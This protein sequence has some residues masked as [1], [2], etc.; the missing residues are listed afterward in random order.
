[1]KSTPLLS[2]PSDT[3]NLGTGKSSKHGWLSFWK[4]L[5]ADKVLQDLLSPVFAFT[6]MI[7]FAVGFV[8]VVVAG[9]GCL[10][11]DF[12][13]LLSVVLFSEAM[14]TF[15]FA[16]F[17][18]Y[19]VCTDI[20]F[21]SAIF[22][23]Q[24]GKTLVTMVGEEDLL[25]YILISQA[26][27]SAV[28]GASLCLLAK[29][30][31][32]W[33]LRFLPYPVSSG[34]AAGIGI[35]IMDGGFELG[36]GIGLQQFAAGLFSG[37]PVWHYVQLALTC[38]SAAVFLALKLVINNALR[39][40]L[41]ILITTGAVH[42]T[43]YQ[44]KFTMHDLVSC[45]MMLEGLSPEPWS[46]AWSSLAADVSSVD[47]SIFVSK[48]WMGIFVPYIFLHIILWS[49]YVSGF[50]DTAD[51]GSDTRIDLNTEVHSTGWTNIMVGLFSGVP[52]CH[53]YKMFLVMKTNGGQSR[54]WVLL[55]GTTF[56]FLFF[57]PAARQPLAV[58]PKLTFGG[59]VLSMGIGFIR[60]AFAQAQKRIAEAER[61]I[62]GLAAFAIYLNVLL[63]LGLGCFLMMVFFIIEYSGITGVTSS[64]TLETVRSLVE[65]SPREN[66][67][68]MHH[69]NEVAVFWCSGYI[70][71]G[72]A[73][74]ITE[75]IDSYL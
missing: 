43:A 71:F 2:V 7:P 53:S 51:L 27:L 59:L 52:T 48:Q 62:V 12:S 63:G 70:F 10:L 31:G 3:D 65:R 39:L 66:A 36:T 57:E 40:P 19:R 38:I 44:L 64:G 42:F 22:L 34:F 4:E 61:R 33:F 9:N 49:F 60:D 1:M 50:E 15:S 56:A 24:V 8:G 17:S 45:G 13:K 75:E 37:L 35:M 41:G 68:L 25:V 21:L 29:N 14:T 26:L 18:Q 74:T 23:G 30:D 16:L 58:I 11:G 28:L 5:F 47:W 54:I 32:L 69:G 55:Y 46:A 6:L 72:T 20:D 73:S 67:T